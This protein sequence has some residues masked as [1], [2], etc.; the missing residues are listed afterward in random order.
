[1]TNSKLVYGLLLAMVA[2]SIAVVSYVRTVNPT[3]S[4]TLDAEGI[5]Q[6][7]RDIRELIS[8]KYV[9]QRVVGTDPLLMVQGNVVARVD[10]EKMQPS[11]VRLTGSTVE[12]RLPGA[13]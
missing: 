10:V 3:H 7:L 8:V 4:V 1:M 5:V 13:K 12:I 9:V 2:L 11:D 6:E